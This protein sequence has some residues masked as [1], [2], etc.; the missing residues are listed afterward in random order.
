MNIKNVSDDDGMILIQISASELGLVEH[1]LRGEINETVQAIAANM[2]IA[3]YE[4]GVEAGKAAA[5]A[6]EDPMDDF[7]YVGSKYHY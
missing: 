1:A 5:A 3:L 6:N 2:K 7:N 4:A